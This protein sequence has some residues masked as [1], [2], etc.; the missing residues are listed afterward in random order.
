MPD[1]MKKPLN[2]LH[3]EDEATDAALIKE[4][5]EADGVPCVIEQVS[6]REAFASA[7][8][9]REY[10]L[11]LSD[12]AL[13]AFDGMTALEMARQKVPEV[14]FI[15]VS[16]TLGE[17][18]AVESL[19]NGATDYVIKGRFPRLAPA[20]RRAMRDAHDRAERKRLEE[21]FVQSQKMEVL[22][23]LAGGIA[24]DFNNILGVIMGYSDLMVCTLNP[25]DPMHEQAR[26][27]RSAAEHAAGLTRQL[28]I[29]SRK[30]KVEL[31]VLDI[32]QVVAEMEKMLRKLIGENID[33]EISP[34]E[35]TWL[36]KADRGHVGQVLMNMAVNARD[37]MPHGGRLRIEIHDV[38]LNE[39]EARAHRDA[40]VG[41][42]VVITVSDT[43]TG[44]T[45]E[46]QARMFEPFFTTKERGKGTGLGL[47]TCHTIVR[48]A[49]G[50]IDVSSRLGEG[51]AFKIYFPRVDQALEIGR[52]A[53]NGEA[54]PR[55][56]ETILFVEDQPAVLDLG[57]S[58]LESHGYRV[59]R[60]A[61]GL[62]GLQA[63]ER[64][65][66]EPVRLVMT[67]VVMPEMGGKV[68]VEWLKATN[69]ELRVLFTSGYTDDAI[70]HYGVLEP[71]VPFL[72]K[73]YSLSGLLQK[74][75]EVLDGEL[76]SVYTSDALV[77]A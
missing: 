77:E 63:V 59:L 17:D 18:L 68:M 51:T 49:G 47:A 5:L 60:A 52:K 1:L 26:E 24:H 6:D 10:D 27:I 3:L 43:G 70:E 25:D 8:E 19:K 7:L 50:H 39:G 65:Q 54:L 56:T 20:V 9:R 15:L 22:G 72:S 46:V 38:T 53:D 61:N 12:Y 28:L 73:P 62:E 13:P 75:R 35:S 34:G 41:D 4:V 64:H 69:P 14:P 42:Y 36:I 48:Q 40:V 37:A 66:G 32:A 11:I 31:V 57:C 67:D 58:V 76:E 23:Q 16:G 74:V 44:M 21:Q 33:L 29:F 71:G 30:Q 45:P 55:G 2:I